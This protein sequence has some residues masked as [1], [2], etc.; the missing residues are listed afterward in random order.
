MKRRT[1]VTAVSAAAL[2]VAAPLLTG[3]S[4]EAHPGAAAVVGDERITI[5]S[6]QERVETVRQAQREQPEGDQ[7]LQASGGL[8]R[9]TVSFLVYLEVLEQTAEANGV[10][11]TRRE[12]QESRALAEAS[13][14]GAEAL[15]RSALVANALPMA[16][17]EQ[18][19]QMLAGQLMFQGLASRLNAPPGPEGDQLIQQALAETAE[20]IGVEVNPRYGEWDSQQ[21]VLAD[22]DTP[23]LR[24]EAPAAGTEGI[25]APPA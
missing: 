1:S 6:V 19:E 3:C 15:E 8:T 20:E 11:I 17:E 21:S 25:P 14:G 12:I 13:A 7:L 24:V 23:W 5:A 16:G 2:L 22:A 18:I 4:T 10:E 9:Q